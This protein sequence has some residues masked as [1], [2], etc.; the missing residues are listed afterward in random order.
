MAT[1]TLLNLI[2]IAARALD[3]EFTFTS[4]YNGVEMKSLN[5]KPAPPQKKTDEDYEPSNDPYAVPGKDYL[6]DD[7][8]M[9]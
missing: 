4:L 1:K 6:K 9:V 5:A 3:P 2:D 8:R 7:R